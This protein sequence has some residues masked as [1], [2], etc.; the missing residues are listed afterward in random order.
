MVF[1]NR[2]DSQGLV[3]PYKDIIF[4]QNRYRMIVDSLKGFERY[5]SLHPLFDKA[6][7]YMSHTDLLSLEPGEYEVDG[8]DI[9][10]I[11]W[12]GEC[13][14]SEI[15]KLEVHDTF[16]DIHLVLKGSETIGLRDR[17]RC[18]GDNIPYDEKRDVALLDETPENFISLGETNLAVIFTHDAHAPLMGRGQLKKAI[19]KIRM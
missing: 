6:F 9:F 18:Q 12:E 17:S 3:N 2:H 10:C 13:I 7:R 1:K 15:P 19:I 16:I 11:I 4:V 8:K 14:E 5:T